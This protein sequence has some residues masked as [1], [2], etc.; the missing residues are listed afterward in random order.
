MKNN[1]GRPMYLGNTLVEKDIMY[2]FDLPAISFIHNG[3]FFLNE[4]NYLDAMTHNPFLSID[5]IKKHV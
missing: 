2:L 4:K 1:K 3:R 5:M